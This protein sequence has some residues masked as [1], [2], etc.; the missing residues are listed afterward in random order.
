MQVISG[1]SRSHMLVSQTSM[2]SAFNSLPLAARKAGSEVEPDSSSPS[3]KMVMLQ[4]RPPLA[5]KARQASTSVMSW[6]LSS[7][8]PARHDLRTAG[9]DLNEARRERIGLPE[10]ERIDRLHVIMAI[11]QHTR[12][13]GA[14]G[15][16][17]GDDHRMALGRPRRRL[18][19]EALQLRHQPVGGAGAIGRVGGIGGDG[20]KAQQVE[21]AVQRA[22]AVGVERCKHIIESG[23][24]GPGLSFSVN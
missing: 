23:H 9:F 15:L 11:D 10:V 17:L 22:L 14:R 8:A 21:Q 7:A 5:R 12:R 1:V 2:R 4:G 19:T 24:D 6:P 18:E 16:G 13:V 20:A 3:N